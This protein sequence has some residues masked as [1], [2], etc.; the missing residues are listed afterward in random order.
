[1]N[2]TVLIPDL[3]IGQE[4]V[5]DQLVDTIS[6][7]LGRRF[8]KNTRD[9]SFYSSLVKLFGLS[10]KERGFPA[11]AFISLG[12]GRPEVTHMVCVS[13][14]FLEAGIEKVYLRQLFEHDLD[15]S[16]AQLLISSLNEFLHDDG[17][18]IEP[19]SNALWMM[20]LPV[21]KVIDTVPLG[22]AANQSIYSLLPKGND[23]IYW[24]KLMNEIQM[25]LFGHQVN[26]IREE[27]NRLPVNGIWFWGEGSLPNAITNQQFDCVLTNSLL[28]KGIAQHCGIPVFELTNKDFKSE[29]YK[30]ILIVDED[31][32]DYAPEEGV[33]SPCLEPN[34][35]CS[36]LG[37]GE[38]L[39]SLRVFGRFHEYRWQTWP[40]WRFW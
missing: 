18:K 29:H 15:N 35:I 6:R 4:N 2:I 21:N 12:I 20:S 38:G 19:V 32:V 31:M 24:H 39:K 1:M 16:S 40:R 23:A 27:E 10:V 37:S 26:H 13:P 22:F 11:A 30:N 25:L 28:V 36:L 8:R 7:Q 3:A 5:L 33:N 17:I 34:N 9:V 14:V